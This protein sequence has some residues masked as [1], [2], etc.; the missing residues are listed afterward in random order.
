MENAVNIGMVTCGRLSHTIK[1]IESLY[2]FDAGFPFHLTVVDNGSIDG[3]ISY[4]QFQQELGHIKNLILLRSN[5]GVAKASNA[6]WQAE[7]TKYYMKMDND[8]II[9]KDNWLFP[10][11]YTIDNLEQL[12]MIGYNFE[13][14]SPACEMYDVTLAGITLTY[15]ASSL[16][17]ACVLIPDRT[18]KILGYWCEEYGL[19][20]EEDVDY[21]IRVIASQKINVYLPD[22]TAVEHLD[23]YDDKD[24]FHKWKS[25]QR[26]II[27]DKCFNNCME[28]L[29]GKRNLYINPSNDA[30]TYRI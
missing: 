14:V 13:T 4:L 5:I 17:G 20:G 26:A 29:D 1:A 10:M 30:D 3:T 7:D 12:G 22:K 19:Y 27:H 18:R 21:G 9:K 2:H 11:V 23:P 16:G 28:Y 6:A 8:V 15:K 24:N 25:Y